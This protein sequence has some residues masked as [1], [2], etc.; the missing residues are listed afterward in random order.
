[1]HTK[2][3]TQIQLYD[4]MN[5][6]YGLIEFWEQFLVIKKVLTFYNSSPG[7]PQDGDKNT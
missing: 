4:F 2:F 6:S 5:R 7:E 1:M 3:K